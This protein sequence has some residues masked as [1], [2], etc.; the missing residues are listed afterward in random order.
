MRTFFK[1]ISIVCL[2]FPLLV[3]GA[4]KKGYEIKIKVG[5][6]KDTVCY[7]ANYFGDKTYLTDTSAVDAQGRFTFKGEEPLQGGI[8]IVALGK[9]RIFEFLVD[10]SQFFSLETTGPDYV[11][12]MKI[13]GSPENQAFYDYMIFNQQRYVEAEP[14]QKLT[15]KVANNKDSAAL[16]KDKL[17]KINKELE[18]YKLNIIKNNPGSLMANFFN[19]MR[20]VSIPEAPTLPNGKKDSAFMYNYYRHHYWDHVDLQD[21]R[22][23]RTPIFQNKVTTYF[24]KVLIQS[25]DTI[26]AES[27]KM[28]EQVRPNKEMFKF[29]VW[30]VTNWSETSKVMGFDKIFV[31]MVKTYYET[32]QA[33]WTNATVVENLV[34]R[35]KKLDAILI[36]KPAPNMMML[37]TNMMPQS[38][39]SIRAKYTILF[40]WDPECGHCKVESPRLKKFYDDFKSK[41]NVEV[42]AICSDT[43]MVKMKEY[44]K[45]N[46]F[47]WI[48]VNGPRSV[49][50]NYHDAYDIYSTP[51]IYILD[52]KKTILAKR[53]A[54]DQI[55]DFLEQY[56]K[57]KAIKKTE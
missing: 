46:G 14:W 2:L 30:F 32:N 12:N 27:D 36:G 13:K 6:I 53:L 5:D 31:H 50:P 49:T 16:V 42:F 48:N 52:E 45:K 40:F 44:I 41:Y 4:S 43:N 8:Y 11:K 33:Y 22:M 57:S 34:K 56:E 25:P 15:K 54:V 28:I 29:F 20:D 55:E 24:E 23:L 7:L 39:T 9:T 18:D 10:K 21:D 17:E 1:S 35:A 37:D 38:M 26:I 19:V 47:N 3:N 51:V